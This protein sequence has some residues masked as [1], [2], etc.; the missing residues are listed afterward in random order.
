MANIGTYYLETNGDYETVESL[1]SETFVEDTTYCF[2]VLTGAFYVR[3]GTQGDGFFV[4]APEKFTF[5][6]GDD[7]LYVKS[8]GHST[9]NVAD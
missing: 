5:T 6:Q 1:I 9:L 8:V 3:E 7:D 4:K 2:Q